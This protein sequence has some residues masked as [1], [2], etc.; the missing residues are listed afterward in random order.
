MYIYVGLCV[1][2]VLMV[3]ASTL[4][5]ILSSYYNLEFPHSY[6]GLRKFYSAFREQF[7]KIKISFN[8]MK[9]ALQSDVIYQTHKIRPSKLLD[10]SVYSLVMGMEC[11]MDA[12][13]TRF[14]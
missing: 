11:V 2:I 12:V 1:S 7:P 6:G 14:G 8:A 4:N 3:K 5:K 9:A 13:C 10:R